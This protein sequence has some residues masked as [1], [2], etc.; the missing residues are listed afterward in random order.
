MIAQPQIDIPLAQYTE[1]FAGIVPHR[2]AVTD[3]AA[4]YSY[5]DLDHAANRVANALLA[6]GIRHGDVVG[7][8]G[9]N[10]LDYCQLLYGTAKS[11]AT[12]LPV[13]WRLAP[14]ELAYILRDAAVRVMFCDAQFAPV[15]ESLR[16]ELPRLERVI[17]VGEGGGFSG[18]RDAASDARPDVAYAAEDVAL[19]FYTSGTTGRPKGVLTSN[20]GLSAGRSAE[21]RM[22]Q[23]YL[24]EPHDVTIAA[25]P[26]SHIGGTGWLLMGQFRGGTMLVLPAPD[27][28]RMLDCVAQHGVTQMFAVPTVVDMM[29]KEQQKRPRDLSTLKYIHYGA[30]S[31]APSQ[32]RDAIETM[33]CGFIQYYGM[34]ETG[35]LM[36]V[37]APDEHDANQPERLKAC[38]KPLPGVS[39]RLCDA[40]GREVRTGEVG[41]IWVRTPAMMNGYLNRP[42]DT[43]SSYTDDWFRTGDAARRDSEGFLYI[44]DR[45]KDMIISG[46]ENVY[47]VEVENALLAHEAVAEAAVIGLPHEKWGEQVAAVIVLKS[48]RQ[49]DAAALETFLRS[50]LAGFKI[51]R[52]YFFAEALPRT[53]S[54]K[55]KKF[56]LRVA[57]GSAEA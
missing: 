32:L 3:G 7:F 40:E 28:A 47:P 44:A 12:L 46:G 38:G 21:R 26:N 57:Y 9:L 54:G 24:A 45:I 51:P 5:R 53:P 31:F 13:N 34:T 20:R 30:S 25:M 39:I 6:D 36:T 11:G 43:A 17:V 4:R 42:E 10:S 15:V 56:E 52:R 49:A 22:G 19:L 50:Q 2:V 33:G 18:W 29:V 48:G 16:S 27:P 14:P 1:H 41:E 37:M 23:W 35:G 8:I 55:I